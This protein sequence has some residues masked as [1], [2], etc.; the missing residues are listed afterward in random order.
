MYDFHQIL[1]RK[2]CHLFS[3]VTLL[4]MGQRARMGMRF[5]RGN[6]L[7]WKEVSA[8]WFQEKFDSGLSYQRGD[9]YIINFPWLDPIYLKSVHLMETEDV[10]PPFPGCTKHI[11][12]YDI[13]ALYWELLCVQNVDF[14]KLS[15]KISRLTLSYSTELIYFQEESCMA[16]FNVYTYNHI[17]KKDT[18]QISSK[19]QK[20]K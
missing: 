14:C 17:Y 7:E 6:L 10:H 13:T 20:Q 2:E 5:T 15:S 4:Q 16:K 11:Q 18:P 19:Y 1:V 8:K 12:Q 9:Q 3:K